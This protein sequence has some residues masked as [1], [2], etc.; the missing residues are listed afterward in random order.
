MLRPKIELLE[1]AT[2]ER[3]IAEAYELLMD[4]G[5]RIHSDEALALLADAGARIDKD[6]RVAHIPAEV[7]R[8]AVETAP[9]SFYL[10]DYEGNAVVHYGGDDVQFDPGSA[11]IEILDYGQ[12]H[13]RKPVTADAVK[14]LK[15]A[16][17]L[18]HIDAVA[19]SLVC[20]DVPEA[21]QD[22]YRLYLVLLYARK[23]VVTGAFAVET[24]AIMKDM[25][26]AVAG[27]QEALAE[28][29]IAVFDAC[30]SPPL[31]WSEIT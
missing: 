4:P 16:E 27:S 25:L 5:V 31:L 24:W 9:S 26:A 29:P 17:G 11:A 8:R 21:M 23:P 14:F 13:S 28:K 19:T 15:L 3:V 18:P 1:Q 12:T 20:D 6:E 7:A 22:L 10:Y 30:P 2:V